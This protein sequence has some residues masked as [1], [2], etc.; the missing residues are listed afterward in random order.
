MLSLHTISSTCMTQSLNVTGCT[1]NL[2]HLLRLCL[3]SS[4][5]S[6]QCRVVS[7]RVM[8]SSALSFVQ[9]SESVLFR[10]MLGRATQP[11]LE[12]SDNPGDR[13]VEASPLEPIDLLLCPRLRQLPAAGT[14][15]FCNH[16][17]PHLCNSPVIP[18]RCPSQ[19]LNGLVIFM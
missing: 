3:D 19:L 9:L 4:L 10:R 15:K 12:V 14:V 11:D 6:R 8:L 17:L 7:F 2:L 1:V 5:H 13:N 18:S 16:S